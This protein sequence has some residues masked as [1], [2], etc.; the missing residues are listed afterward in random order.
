[1]SDN[2]VK[3]NFAQF[4]GKMLILAILALIGFIIGVISLFVA[5]AGYVGYVIQIASLIV[6]ILALVNIG[7]IAKKLNNRDLSSFRSKIILALILSFIGGILFAIGLAAILAIAYGP[8]PGAWEGYV[9]FGIMALIGLVLMIVGAIL[10][11]LAWND[12]K[13]FFRDNKSMFPEPIGKSAESGSKFLM[14]GSIFT[15]TIILAF[16]GFIF[17]VIGYFKL[18][19]LKKLK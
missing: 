11:I 8:D 2:D 12:L 17:R 19:A 18:S 6:L 3:R 15:L 13:H 14:I 16:I 1:M 9:V 4:G 7:K 5:A 10:E